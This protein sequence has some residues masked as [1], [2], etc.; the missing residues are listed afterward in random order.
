MGL[1]MMIV[2]IM[3]IFK[4]LALV[5]GNLVLI[6]VHSYVVLMIYDKGWVI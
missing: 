5:I 4:S 1:V 6:C 2:I 3:I